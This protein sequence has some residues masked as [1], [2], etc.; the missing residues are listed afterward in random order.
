MPNIIPPRPPILNS[1]NPVWIDRIYTF[2]GSAATYTIRNANQDILFSGKAYAYPST[3]TCTINLN[4]VCENYLENDLSILKQASMTGTTTHTD[5]AKTFYVYDVNEEEV[6]SYKCYWN[7]NQREIIYTG[8]LSAPINGHYAVNMKR[9]TTTIDTSAVTTE[10][11]NSFSEWGDY[12]TEACGDYALYYL[13]RNGG[14]DAFLIEG[15]VVEKDTFTRSTFESKVNQSDYK[16]RET[17][18]YRNSIEHS[19][20]LNTGWLKDE[21]S[22]RLAYHLLSSNKVYLHNLNTLEII[23]VNI[24]DSVVEYKNFKNERRLYSYS[25][26]VKE[27]NKQVI[28]C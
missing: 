17:N 26:N 5:A 19:Y 16:S 9:F 13:N 18:I 15:K 8:K 21:E 25:I 10:W 2:T 1:Y 4:H 6:D 7:Y 28:L 22:E 12:T 14:W 23:P 24:T 20:E 3:N 27:S 11:N